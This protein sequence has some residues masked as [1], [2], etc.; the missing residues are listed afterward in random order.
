M[1]KLCI[2]SFILLVFTGFAQTPQ[3]INGVPFVVYHNHN[4][5]IQRN[6]VELYRG[7]DKILTH[8]TYH[9][10]GDCSSENL[11]LGT[12]DIKDHQIIFYSYWASGDR[13][14]V[15]I[16][17]FGFRKQ[18]Y[19]VDKHGVV[20]LAQAQIY[21]VTGKQVQELLTQ[22]SLS[23]DK[24]KLLKQYIRSIE[25]DYSATFVTGKERKILEQDVRLTLKEAIED[26]TKDWAEIF[27][28]YHK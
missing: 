16:F 17:P 20:S 26:H 28:F 14:G 2:I 21:M 12:Y 19:T 27:R 4:A 11:E 1:K 13:M 6:A 25:K 10:E 5:S 22:Q 3:T 18:I 15:N 9:T 23:A 7:Q 24:Q 8:T